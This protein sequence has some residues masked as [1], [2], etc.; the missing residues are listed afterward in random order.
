MNVKITVERSI[1]VATGVSHLFTGDVENNT[2]CV[3]FIGKTVIS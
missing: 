2:S 1:L 3:L